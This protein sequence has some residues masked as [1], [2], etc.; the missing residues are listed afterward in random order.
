MG[1][2]TSNAFYRN[3]ATGSYL[4]YSTTYYLRV[5][6]GALSRAQ[7]N[8]RTSFTFTSHTGTIPAD[9]DVDPVLTLT[10]SSKKLR[11]TTSRTEN[12]TF[13]TPDTYIPLKTTYGT[14]GYRTGITDESNTGYIVSGNEYNTDQYG[15]IRI[16]AFPMSS[17]LSNS[18]TSNLTTVYT[19]NASGRQTVTS[20]AA[21]GFTKFDESKQ[22][23]VNDVLK[24]NGSAREYVY[25]MHFMPATIGIQDS[26]GHVVTVPRAYI[27]GTEY[28]NYQLPHDCVDFN[29]KEKGYINFFGGTY[30]AGNVT[31]DN[32]SFFSLYKIERDPA[33]N[34]ISSILRITEIFENKSHQNYSYIYRLYDPST[35]TYSYTLPYTFAGGV[36]TYLDG[37]TTT[38]LYSGYTS[39]FNTGWIENPSSYG[40]W[41]NYAAYYYEIPMNDG[42]FALGSVEGMYG[43][44]LMYLDIGANASKHQ[45]TIL[46]EH[47]GYVEIVT[48]YPMGVALV[49]LPTTFTKEV[50]VLDV[51]VEIDYTDS[52]CIEIP[53]GYTNS[54]TIDRNAGDVT[55]S[56]SNQT[57]APPVYAGEA[58]TLIH[59]S[60]SSTNIPLVPISSETRDVKR[61]T[62]IDYNL[63]MDSTTKTIITDTKI[64]NGTPTRTIAQYVYSG[65]NV[66]STPIST[67]IY[68]STTDQRSSMKVY[69]TENG[70]RYSAAD[71]IDDSVLSIGTVSNTAIMVVRIIQDNGEGYTEDIFAEISLDTTNENG[72]YFKF[73][74]YLITITPD[75]ADVVIKVK[76]ITSGKVI[77]YGTTQVTGANQTI[78][79]EA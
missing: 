3:S 52:A 74:D 17:S 31:H 43:A 26:L 71:L 41:T 7:S 8:Q 46:N 6:N 69:N 42:E 5:N 35:R 76:S 36:K 79:I 58:I 66:T 20:N 44:Y 1:T 45:R 75:G 40:T 24:E 78:T 33:T 63:V 16:S 48:A 49:T 25:G 64:G 18:G 32:N 62:Y 21:N 68:D 19:I 54:L 12:S 37:A 22:T 65:T 47:F 30:Y 77:Y 29:L 15:D 2:T 57:N 34:N 70:I 53:G 61:L 56:R 67:Y 9:I 39:V 27:N 55:L 60:G 23:M 10:N 28:L 50:A 59:D 73:N 51:S 72:K 11:Y 4:Q 14:D 13:Y 38:S